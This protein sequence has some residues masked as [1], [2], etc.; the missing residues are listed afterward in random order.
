M[1]RWRPGSRRSFQLSLQE[2]KTVGKWR[3]FEA[4]FLMIG[5]GLLWLRDRFHRPKYLKP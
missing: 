2:G 5:R 4:L 1:H 3:P